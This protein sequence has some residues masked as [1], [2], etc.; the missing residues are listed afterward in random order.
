MIALISIKTYVVATTV[1]CFVCLTGSS[2]AASLTS[3]VV[4]FDSQTIQSSGPRSGGGQ[5]FFFNI[6]GSNND[7]F[8]SYGIVDFE[9]TNSEFSTT[10]LITSVTDFRLE[11]IQNDPFFDA[12]GSF[13]V[14]FT[15]GNSTA[16][17]LGINFENLIY[18]SFEGGNP[19]IVSTDFPSDPELIGSDF[20]FTANNDL[21][22]TTM[23]F[24]SLP[25]TVSDA[26][27]AAINNG[28]R[29]SFILAPGETDP[30]VS[31]T[32]SGVGNFDY[33]GSI[34]DS[35]GNVLAGPSLTGMTVVLIPEPSSTLLIGLAG[36]LLYW[37]RRR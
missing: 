35:K 18:D 29:F 31:A 20:S 17:S 22:L 37:R 12:S 6:Q 25:K 10:S 24:N 13:D 11:L 36:G 8:A 33:D 34:F 32:F 7:D 15:S 5:P 21:A 26:M 4:A 27:A 30:D 1:L 28:T 3:S 2:F 16:E 14:Y 23:N 19:G 9:L